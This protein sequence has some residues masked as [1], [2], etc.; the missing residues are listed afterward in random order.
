MILWRLSLS[1]LHLTVISEAK[2]S[3]PRASNKLGDWLIDWVRDF[4]PWATS[5]MKAAKE[6]KFDTKV[7]YG[8][9][10]MAELRIHA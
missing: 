4:S 5:A 10:M 8:V 6:T 2:A 7:A 3:V 9:R 1:I